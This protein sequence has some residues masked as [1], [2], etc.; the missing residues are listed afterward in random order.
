[1]ADKIVHKRSPLPVPFLQWL[2][3]AN[4]R[5][6]N[7]YGPDYMGQHSDWP[8]HNNIVSEKT[9]SGGFGTYRLGLFEPKGRFQIQIGPVGRRTGQTVVGLQQ[10]V[11]GGPGGDN[12]VR[13]IVAVDG[14][15]KQTIE[16]LNV[17]NASDMFEYPRD[18]VV[19]T[20]LE[21]MGEVSEN[22]PLPHPV[23]IPRNE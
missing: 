19:Y 14:K 5:G 23:G 18:S 17:E 16:A 20:M 6:S 9:E 12:L 4:Y 13:W 1:M 7:L 3:E 21:Q 22:P 15:E 10:K 2:G 8:D 11:V